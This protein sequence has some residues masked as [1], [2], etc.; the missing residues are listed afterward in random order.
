MNASSTPG[1]TWG[2]NRERKRWREGRGRRRA[3]DRARRPAGTAD[4]ARAEG[5]GSAGRARGHPDVQDGQGAVHHREG[6]APTAATRGDCRRVLTRERT[7]DRRVR[8]T[9]P[10]QFKSKGDTFR[11]FCSFGTRASC[12]ENNA[13]AD[14]CTKVRGALSAAGVDAPPDRAPAASQT[15]VGTARS[16]TFGRSS[17]PTRSNASASAST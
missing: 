6:G 16:C 5:A 13:S 9:G 10:R 11:E 3:R 14:T 8:D 15:G 1:R 4:R 12:K 7:T 2:L 17:W